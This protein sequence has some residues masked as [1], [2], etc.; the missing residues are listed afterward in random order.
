MVSRNS[1]EAEYRSLALATCELIWLQR[2]LKD[3]HFMPSST[4]KLFCDNKS[5]L[6]IGINPV[7]YERTKHI[8]IECHTVRD[9]LKAGR[10]RTMHVSSSNQLADVLTKALHPDPFYSLVHRLSLSSLF[11]PSDDTKIKT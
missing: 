2:L 6:H 11:L 4:A 5:A 10:L 9:Q 1:T 7:F 3:L 8:D